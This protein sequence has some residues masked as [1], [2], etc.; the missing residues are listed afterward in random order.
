MMVNKLKYFLV[1]CFLLTILSC[2]NKQK[3]VMNEQDSLREIERLDAI[4]D[5]LEFQKSLE[6]QSNIANIVNADIETQPVDSQDGDDAADDP[7]IWVNENDPAKS[8]ILGTNKRA[9]LYVYN[10]AGEMLQFNKVGKINNVDLRSGYNYRNKDVVLVAGSNRTINAISLFIIDKEKLT[11][12]DTLKNIKSEVDEVYGICMYKNQKTKQFFVFV[13]GKDGTIEQWEIKANLEAVKVRSF[14]TNTQ[15]EGMAVNDKTAMLYIGVEDEC[16]YKMNANPD[17]STE[18]TKLANSDSTNSA[19]KYDIEGIAI[20][21]YKGNDY[22]IASSQG[23][24]SYSIFKLGATDSYVTSFIIKDADFDGVEE[25]DGLDIAIGSFNQYFPNGILVV[26]DGYNYNNNVK[27]KQNFKYISLE[28]I[29]KFI[30]K[31]Q[32]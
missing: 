2:G 11:L 7:A 6:A 12:S 26:Q 17:A 30:D 27:D 25:T 16:I 28:K 1:A 29:F 22:L 20:F 21:P 13:N 18:M 14:N 24:F 19:I 9:G 31:F 5:S 15:P 8:L 4:E 3:T 32:N 23:N 10:L